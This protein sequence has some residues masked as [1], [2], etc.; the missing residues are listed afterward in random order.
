MYT[1]TPSTIKGVSSHCRASAQACAWRRGPWYASEGWPTRTV[2]PSIS[3]TTSVTVPAPLWKRS[4][5]RKPN[6]FVIQTAA[7]PASSYASIGMTRCS[8]IVGLLRAFASNDALAPR[9]ERGHDARVTDAVVE[10]RDLR[11]TFRV[12]ERQ[13]GLAATLRSFVLRQRR[14]INAVAGITF[15]IE[16]GE[17]RGFLCPNGAGKTDTLTNPPRALTPTAPSIL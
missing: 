8:A 17:V 11:K 4:T 6:T 10:V 2:A 13:E 16:A 7:W 12:T 5:S 9:S 15:G 1:T 14:D 3:R